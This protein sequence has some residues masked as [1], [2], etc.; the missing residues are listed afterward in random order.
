MESSHVTRQ[1]KEPEQCAHFA[2]VNMYR[3]LGLDP[4]TRE[5]LFE[6]DP[7]GERSGAL[8]FVQAFDILTSLPFPE[9]VVFIYALKESSY[10]CG[11]ENRG[12]LSTGLPPYSFPTRLNRAQKNY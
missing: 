1:A 12:G 6:L 11:G 8:C 7:L 5:R 9:P 3:R 4:P 2:I 10:I